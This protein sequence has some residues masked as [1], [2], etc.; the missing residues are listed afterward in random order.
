ML[1]GLYHNT[2]K[3]INLKLWLKLSRKLSSLTNMKS[4]PDINCQA[5][6]FIETVHA[7]KQKSVTRILIWNKLPVEQ[8]F[9]GLQI[10]LWY[11]PVNRTRDTWWQ[12]RHTASKAN[13][14]MHRCKGV[15]VYFLAS[16]LL[17]HECAP[18]HAP[19]VT[20]KTEAVKYEQ[21]P[22]NQKKTQVKFVYLVEN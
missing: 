7:Q 17:H 20:Q 2:K 6:P 10:W 19:Q 13:K 8:T 12:D 4:R 21:N 18:Q 14:A 9:Y 22:K 16:C 15:S 11:E 1:E 5:C 3:Q